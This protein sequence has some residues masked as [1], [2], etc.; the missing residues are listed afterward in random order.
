MSRASH[1]EANHTEG[2]HH[3]FTSSATQQNNSAINTRVPILLLACI[4][5]RDLTIG[6]QPLN[7][8]ALRFTERKEFVQ[9]MLQTTNNPVGLITAKISAKQQNSSRLTTSNIGH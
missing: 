2:C 1:G 6:V 4:K 7:K 5:C 9:K 3:L 8:I